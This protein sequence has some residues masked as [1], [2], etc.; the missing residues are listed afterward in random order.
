MASSNLLL[1]RILDQ[2]E[3]PR[4][5]NFAAV[6]HRCV[7][8]PEAGRHDRPG[9]HAFQDPRSPR[10]PISSTSHYAMARVENPQQRTLDERLCAPPG[11]ATG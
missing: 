4:I 7:R 5:V 3:R 11:V 1:W 8:R 6:G 9:N 2:V 10:T